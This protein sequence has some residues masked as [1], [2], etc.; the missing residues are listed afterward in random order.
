MENEL[1]VG[2]IVRVKDDA[3]HPYA[4]TKTHTG[5]L[6]V[7]RI[8]ELPIKNPPEGAE[9]GIIL[10]RCDGEN[11]SCAYAGDKYDYKQEIYF[12][13]D[14]KLIEGRRF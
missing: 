10:E 12:E 13:S 1:K 5:D 9:R 6:V 11:F 2:D 8:D 4:I 3:F 7:V 14:L